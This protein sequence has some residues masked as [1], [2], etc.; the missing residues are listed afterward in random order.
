MT[1]PEEEE[2]AAGLK[3]FTLEDLLLLDLRAAEE[4]LR[5]NCIDGVEDLIQRIRNLAPWHI[6][7]QVREFLRR[8]SAPA[9]EATQ[10][11]PLFDHPG[12]IKVWPRLVPRAECMSPPVLLRFKLPRGRMRSTRYNWWRWANDPDRVAADLY[13]RLTGKPKERLREAIEIVN[14]QQH[15]G[16]RKAD[17]RKVRQLLHRNRHRPPFNR[18]DDD[19]NGRR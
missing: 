19:P 13:T 17:P 12:P 10:L 11:D 3:E 15:S 2:W 14:A 8:H 1:A 6:P 4:D 7:P 16:E 9:R 5:R 18:Y